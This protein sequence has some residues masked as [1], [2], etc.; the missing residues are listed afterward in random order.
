MYNIEDRE[1]SNLKSKSEQKGKKQKGKDNLSVSVERVSSSVVFSVN[2]QWEKNALAPTFTANSK[3]KT[4]DAEVHDF[5]DGWFQTAFILDLL[6][7][8]WNVKV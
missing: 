7:S 4:A 2:D 1:N 8:R 6:A 5:Y 3:T